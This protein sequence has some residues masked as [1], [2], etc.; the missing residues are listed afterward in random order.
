MSIATPRSTA[1]ATAAPGVP[2]YP[3]DL[4][5][6]LLRVFVGL[7]L[8]AHGS[9]KLFGW[10]GGQGV[11][12]TGHY[13]GKLGYPA[14]DWFAVVNGV[15]ETFGGLF[16]A[17]GFLTPLAAAAAIG[18]MV[19]AVGIDWRGLSVAGFFLQFDGIEYPLLLC[20]AS[21]ALALTGPGVYSVDHYLPVLRHYRLAYGFGAI[22]LGVVVGVVVLMIR[23]S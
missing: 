14:A 2:I 22:V 9:Q 19:N 6:L 15:C 1:R 23:S 4:G 18:T 11:Q 12:G 10:F 13:L 20:A 21:A 7:T 3:Y 8:A 17:L 5:L 16:L